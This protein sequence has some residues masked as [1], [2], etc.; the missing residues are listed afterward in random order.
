MS[1]TIFW[2]GTI[3]LEA[4]RGGGGAYARALFTA[5]QA[6]APEAKIVRLESR[7][8]GRR[9]TLQHRLRQISSLLRAVFSSRSAK[10][11]FDFDP[12]LEVR[13]EQALAAQVPDR[14]IWMGSSAAL[15][16]PLFPREIPRILIAANLEFSLYREQLQSSGWLSRRLFLRCIDEPTKHERFERRV[17][18]SV[19]GC[20]AISEEEAESIRVMSRSATSVVALPAVSS[21]PWDSRARRVHRGA[22]RGEPGRPLR[23][24]FLG[25]L[26]WWPNQ[27]AVRWFIEEVWPAVLRPSLELHLYGEG[28]EALHEPSRR[29]FGHGF[30]EDLHEIWGSVDVF[31]NPMQGGAGVN[32]KVCDALFHG[33][34]VISSTKGLRG[35]G[36]LVDPAIVEV[37]TA[38][39]WCDALGDE[40]LGSLRE[41][42]PADSLRQR[43]SLERA[44]EAWR[45][46]LSRG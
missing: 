7:A 24:G 35:L 4:H 17:F 45:S 23:L 22:P 33:L 39:E 36:P 29:V 13:I 18:S 43:F 1:Q 40:A 9:S 32:V 21:S 16:D 37:N 10:L 20:L 15:Y 26:S 3:D 11:W 8:G 2:V 46:L 27:Q 28:S 5:L 6:A 14:I 31:V 44:V 25:K 12:E 41:R 38:R 19:E 34:P 42:T 30:V